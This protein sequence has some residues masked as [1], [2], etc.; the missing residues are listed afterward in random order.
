MNTR[1]AGEETHPGLTTHLDGGTLTFSLFP[2]SG[3]SKEE[4][5][6]PLKLSAQFAAYVW[7]SETRQG[8][9]THEESARFARES[10]ASFLPSAHE[11]LGRLL[12]RVGKPRS[13]AEGRRKLRLPAER[14]GESPIQGMAEAG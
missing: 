8:R 5:M 12:I 9:A 13:R 1:L 4:A 7:Y 11:G 2:T 3:I 14:L 10:W 6:N